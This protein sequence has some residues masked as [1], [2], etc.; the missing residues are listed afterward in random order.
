MSSPILTD[1]TPRAPEF[2][3]AGADTAP[4]AILALTC[5]APDTRTL[6]VRLRGEADHW[7]LAPL[8]GVLEE[9]RDRGRRSLVL[10]CRELTFCDSALLKVLDGWRCAGGAY[11][12]VSL[13]GTLP[14]LM[15]EL[16]LAGASAPAPLPAVLPGPVPALVPRPGPVPAG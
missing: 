9:A 8:R 16:L 2:E 13:P 7:S 14:A 5:T 6:T 15:R 11:R 1:T 10:D 3:G 12:V 4:G